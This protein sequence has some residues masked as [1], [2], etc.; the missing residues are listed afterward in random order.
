MLRLLEWS[1]E[2][3]RY[4]AEVRDVAGRR[5][6]FVG[7]DDELPREAFEVSAADENEDALRARLVRAVRLTD[8]G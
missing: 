7:V 4:L 8:L 5:V 1:Q 3:H 2:G 6:W